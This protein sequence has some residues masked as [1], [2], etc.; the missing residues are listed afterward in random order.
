MNTDVKFIINLNSV[1]EEQQMNV[2]NVIRQYIQDLC[3]ECYIEMEKGYI[4]RYIKEELK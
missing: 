3:G 2:I 4:D 1:R